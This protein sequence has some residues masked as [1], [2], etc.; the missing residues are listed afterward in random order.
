VLPEVAILVPFVSAR[1]VRN[2]DGNVYGLVNDFGSDIAVVRIGA[3]D[4]VDG[5]ARTFSID[6]EARRLRDETELVGQA[7]ACLFLNFPNSTKVKSRQAEACP[8]KALLDE[9]DHRL[10][11]AEVKSMFALKWL[12]MAAGVAM[13]GTAA[14]VVSYDVYLAMQFQKL[15]GSGDPGAA[16]KAGPRRPIRWPLAARL[17]GWAWAPLLLALSITLVPEGSGGVRISQIS[18]VKQGTLYPGLHLVAPLVQSVAVYDLRDRL[19]TTIASHETASKNQLLTVQ[20]REGLTIGLAISVRY[21]LDPERLGYIHSNLTQP[22]DTEIVAPVVSTAFRDIAPNYV[23]REVFSTKRDEFRTRTTKAIVDRLGLDGIVVKEVLLRDVHLPD[24]YAKGLEGILLK[25][26]ESERVEFETAI[27]EKQVKI[28]ELQAEAAKAQ[29]VKRAEADA[30]S[31][32]IGAKAESDAMQYTLPL[33]QKQIEQSRLEAQARKEATEENAEAAAAAK[34][35]DSKAEAERRRVLASADADTTRLN[36]AA[37]A[38]TI[39]LTAAADAERLQGEAA[40]LKQNPML[41]QKI[42]AERLSDKLQIIM[43]PTDGR[44]FFASDVLRSAFEGGAPSSNASN[45][46]EDSNDRDAPAPAHK[47]AQIVKTR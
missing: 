2:C 45:D 39:R 11:E 29:Q 5:P 44:N 36:A 30:A 41:I 24:E 23:V 31:R 40:V 10:E 8:T 13:F 12:L 27:Y 7:S 9:Q 21:R 17:F 16:E 32:V 43:V 33:K 37:N 6:A 38:D 15:M 19:F 47:Q 26:Q 28:A 4:R 35:T 20:T 22:V 25:E 1:K 18:G 14:G 46:A 42:I 3:V 34:V